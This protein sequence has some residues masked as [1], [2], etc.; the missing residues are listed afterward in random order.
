MSGRSGS[1]FPA[2]QPVPPIHSI[3]P[4]RTSGHGQAQ[5]LPAGRSEAEGEDPGLVWERARGLDC[6]WSTEGAAFD[7][8]APGEPFQN[9]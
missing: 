4:D 7:N 3:N 9:S 6:G 8:R 2:L 1:T 5:A